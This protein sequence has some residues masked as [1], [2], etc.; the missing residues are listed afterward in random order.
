MQR[1]LVTT[2]LAMVIAA[3]AVKAQPISDYSNTRST[4]SNTDYRISSYGIFGH[5][6]AGSSPGFFYPRNSGNSYIY[7]SGVWFGAQKRESDTLRKL[8]FMTYN[9]NS[10]SSWATPGDYTTGST[11]D[12]SGVYEARSYD[13]WTG[14]KDSTAGGPKG[15]WPLWLRP[16]ATTTLFSTGEYVR[17]PDARHA[18]DTFQRP[19]FMPFVD[20]QFVTRFH[21]GNLD[22]YEG[23]RDGFGFPLG[24]QFQQSV[25]SWG[26]GSYENVVVIQYEVVNVS[27]DTLFNCV[28][29]QATDPDLGK[30][31]NDRTSIHRGRDGSMRASIVVTEANEVREYD[32]LATVLLE[33]P[34]PGP[35][36]GEVAG[37]VD[38]S[39]RGDR[40]RLTSIHNYTDWSLEEDPETLD[41]RYDMLASPRLDTDRGPGDKRTIIAGRP[42]SMLPGDTAHFAIAYAVVD[43]TLGF[44]RGG[45]DDGRARKVSPGGLAIADLDQFIATIA[46]DYADGLFQLGMPS[47][48][49]DEARSTA[50]LSVGPNPA[51]TST[52]IELTLDAPGTVDVM[53]VNTM[54]ERVATLVLGHREAGAHR[55]SLDLSSVPTGSYMLVVDAEGTRRT[56]MLNVVR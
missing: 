37:F 39:M 1:T 31:Q 32:A 20:E 22:R 50:R 40:V 2:V 10:G 48:V 15:N 49:E 55:V 28:I 26:E 12:G 33:S 51:S 4:L 34:T 30:A 52:T 18:G 35:S 44:A 47:A 36:I 16:G 56:A 41:E 27:S 42:F 9:P 6:V 5:D 43:S 38:N 21:D 53:V 24:L 14:E 19:S 46:E 45:D 13:Q 17:D 25:Y 3:G 54:G 7:G 8:V 23:F 11:I 29:G